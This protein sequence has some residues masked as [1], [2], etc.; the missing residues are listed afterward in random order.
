V[1]VGYV[2][3]KYLVFVDAVNYIFALSSMDI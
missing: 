1:T 2:G 3:G